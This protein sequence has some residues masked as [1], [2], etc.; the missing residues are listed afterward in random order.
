[1]IQV[2]LLNFGEGKEFG[3]S[4]VKAFEIRDQ[5]NISSH[6]NED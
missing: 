5:T 2:S 1:M 3:A 6:V 4:V